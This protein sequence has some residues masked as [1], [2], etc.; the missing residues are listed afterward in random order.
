MRTERHYA[1]KFMP[2]ASILLRIDETHLLIVKR[3]RAQRGVGESV[4]RAA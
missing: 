4:R 3:V 1:S 2:E